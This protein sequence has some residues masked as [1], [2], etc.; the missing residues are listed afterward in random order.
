MITQLHAHLHVL[1]GFAIGLIVCWV[2]LPRLIWLSPRLGLVDQPN[3]RKVHQQL[4]PAIGGLG[5][6]LA[7]LV[8]TLCYP[9][10]RDFF[11]RYTAL[12]V[13]LPLLMLTGVLDDRLNLRA[14]LRLLIQVSCALAVAHDGIRLTS[15]HGVF[16]LTELPLVA[17]YLLTVVILTGMANAFNLIDGVDGLAGSLALVNAVLLGSLAALL[18]Q[19]QWLALLSPLAGA[20]LAFLNVNWRPA[21][22]F[23]GDGGSVVLGF[24]MATI[25]IALLEGAYQHGSAY[26]PQAFSLITASCIMPVLDALRVFASRMAQG[27]SPFSADRNHVHHWLLKHR[28]AHSQITVRLVSVHCFGIALSVAASFFLSISATLLV[29]IG[30]VVAYTLLVQLSHAFLQSYRLVKKLEVS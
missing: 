5:I 29:Q 7:L 28:F 6:G 22:L 2:L 16:G 27:R 17:Q 11:G 4:I 21:R 23:M 8:T 25:G 24:L 13:T 20:L 30:I 14:S 1:A 12:A 18:H 9:P 26:R 15:L 3:N 19:P 10:L